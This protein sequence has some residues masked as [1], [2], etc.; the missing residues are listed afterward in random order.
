[1]K[2]AAISAIWVLICF[3][4]V[5]SAIALTEV[6]YLARVETEDG[7][8]KYYDF[9]EKDGI[10]E[11]V[12]FDQEK[13]EFTPYHKYLIDTWDG[14]EICQESLDD[15]AKDKEEMTEAGLEVPEQYKDLEFGNMVAMISCWV[16][17]GLGFLSIVL[18]VFLALRLIIRLLVALGKSSKPKYLYKNYKTFR[19]FWLIPVIPFLVL[20]SYWIPA[21]GANYLAF[22]TEKAMVEMMGGEFTTTFMDYCKEACFIP[23]YSHGFNFLYV[24]AAILAGYIVISILLNLIIKNKAPA[25]IKD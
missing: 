22:T 15:L 25:E 9:I 23:A 21:M 8:V 17:L 2:K 16:G 24:A 19:K 13:A 1:M 11:R 4:L 10:E 6:T 18:L 12:E 7:E 14:A 3:A 5:V 20:G